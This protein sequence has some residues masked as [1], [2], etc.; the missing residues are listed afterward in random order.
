MFRREDL[1]IRLSA[2]DSHIVHVS[3]ML[4]LITWVVML[5]HVFFSGGVFAL[6][7]NYFRES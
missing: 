3:W 2:G 6:F 4:T 7:E 5:P 1:T